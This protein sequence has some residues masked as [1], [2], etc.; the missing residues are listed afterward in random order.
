MAKLIIKREKVFFACARAFKVFVDG[1]EAGR[2]RNGETVEIEVPE[3][4]HEVWVRLDFIRSKKL[5]F[6][7]ATGESE[8]FTCAM[9][10]LAPSLKPSPPFAVEPF[11]G[12]F[13]LDTTLEFNW[14]TVVV[15]LLF[16]S[17]MALVVAR[18]YAVVQLNGFKGVD[19]LAFDGEQVC[20]HHDRTLY[21]LTP[22]GWLRDSI[23]LAE[24]GISG[25]VA[26]LEFVGDGRLLVGDEGR[27]TVYS[28]DLGA[29]ACE[30]LRF[31]GEEAVRDNFKFVYDREGDRLY[32]TDTNRHA[33]LVK[34]LGEE[35]SRG[36]AGVELSYPNDL[37]VGMGGALLIADTK[38]SRIVRVAPEGSVEGDGGE[39]VVVDM[40]SMSEPLASFAGVEGL[41]EKVAVGA[42]SS[43]PAPLA[44]AGDPAGNWWVVV[45]DAYINYGEVWKFSPGGEVLRKIALATR[46][47]PLDIIQ[48]GRRLLVSDTEQVR[49]LAID[50]ETGQQ[51]IFGDEPFRLALDEMRGQRD[52]YR[53]I[54]N[55]SFKYIGV[56]LVGL[57]LMLVVHR[58]T[59]AAKARARRRAGA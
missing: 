30:P 32:L 42:V 16:F 41:T 8:F 43:Y 7:A 39:T 44:L 36:L 9:G 22:G 40:K 19:H 47:I 26:D 51:E 10:L 37:V 50:P 3:G 15:F 28:C 57:L 20:V 1:R 53:Q 21:L 52:L 33:L 24:L 6:T 29:R 25:P 14:Q 59:Q 5:R 12:A 2:V 31:T 23:P 35:G 34:P 18:S 55:E 4:G 46:S 38:N 11:M 13:Q 27:G 17:V 58:R 56:L 54:K 48:V 49:V 45:A